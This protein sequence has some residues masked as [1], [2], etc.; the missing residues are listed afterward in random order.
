MKKKLIF[1]PPGTGKTTDLMNRL[2]SELAGTHASEIAFVSFT[3]Q[4]TYEG[5]ERAIQKFGLQSSETRY[6]KTIHSLCFHALGVSKSMMIAR[7][8][9]KLLSEK[10]GIAFTGYYTQ[11]M[12]STNDV[13]LHAMSME[14][15]NKEFGLRIAKDINAKTYEYVKF[16]Y[17]TM[18]K[19]IGILDFDDLLLNYLTYGDPLDIRVA[20]IDEA[21][22]LTPLQWLVIDKMFSNAER[23]YVAG[24]DDQ[25]VY[26]WSGA[27]VN[28]FLEYSDD[29]I[30]LNRSYRLPSNILSMA[31]NITKDIGV[32]KAKEFIGKDDE[33]AINSVKNLERVELKGG[34]LVLARTNWILKSMS[35]EFSTRGIPYTLRKRPSIEPLVLRA[36]MAHIDFEKGKTNIGSINKYR[37]MFNALNNA[38]WWE[39]I[40]LKPVQI[41]HYKQVI[42]TGNAELAPVKFETFHSCKG[43][44]NTHVIVNTDLSARVYQSMHKN[45]DAELR[46]LYVGMTRTLKDLT[47]LM[48]EQKYFY[49]SKYF[50]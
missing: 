8:H 26:E 44:E 36:I 13:F 46:C 22:D 43:S 3:R 9:Y 33:G 2:E 35:E 11:D 40:Q 38:P 37:T 30:V 34:E 19:Q 6:F 16:Q 25:A 50:K 15:H 41:Q 45:Y 5:V 23:V 7:N 17:E 31:K 47:I 28:K 24:D 27:K 4:G 1:G 21:Q 12:S 18:K 42:A 49:P 14:K 39:T 48:P 29:S 32:R 20:F 10:T